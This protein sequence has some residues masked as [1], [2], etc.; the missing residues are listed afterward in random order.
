[1][2]FVAP[3]SAGS[4]AHAKFQVSGVQAGAENSTI[5]NATA[6]GGVEVGRARLQA[7]QRRVFDASEDRVMGFAHSAYALALFASLGRAPE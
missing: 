6:S 7:I 2:I 3:C 4:V 5:Y 1:L